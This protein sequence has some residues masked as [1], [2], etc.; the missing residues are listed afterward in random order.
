M[1]VTSLAQGDVGCGKTVVA[2]LALL[3][4]TG[5]GFQGAMM[6]PTEASL[7]TNAAFNTV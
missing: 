7:S 6:A 2:F 5:S 1:W 3:A 4:A